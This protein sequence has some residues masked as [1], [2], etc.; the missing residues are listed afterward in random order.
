MRLTMQRLEPV[1]Q[2]E[3]GSFGANRL[4]FGGKR[5]R[6][7]AMVFRDGPTFRDLSILAFVG[8]RLE[9]NTAA[10]HAPHS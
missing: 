10:V 9:R 6:A 5:K 4:N 7:L 8:G 3:P 1:C 2:A